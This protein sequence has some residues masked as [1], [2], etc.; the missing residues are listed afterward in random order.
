MSVT[1]TQDTELSGLTEVRET[2]NVVREIDIFNAVRLGK[3]QPNEPVCYKLVLTECA[4]IVMHKSQIT[5]N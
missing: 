1:M 2:L 5:T 4:Q 3:L